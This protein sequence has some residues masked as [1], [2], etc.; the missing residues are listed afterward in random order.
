MDDALFSRKIGA[1]N[2][3]LL[4]KYRALKAESL[5]PEEMRAR[6]RKLLDAHQ[7]KQA[8]I[9]EESLNYI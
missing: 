4:E 3:E 8:E 9:F 6:I 1:N 5:P 7:T 2:A